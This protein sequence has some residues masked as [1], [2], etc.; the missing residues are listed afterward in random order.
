MAQA[1]WPESVC[2]CLSRLVAAG[3]KLTVEFGLSLGWTLQSGRPVPLPGQPRRRRRWLWI[4]WWALW[5]W[6]G[7]VVTPFAEE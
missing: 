3:F 7:V 2:P 6:F 4:L 5:W 1:V